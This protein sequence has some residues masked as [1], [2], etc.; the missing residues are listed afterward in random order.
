MSDI[1]ILKTYLAYGDDITG[2]LPVQ[3]ECSK[4]KHLY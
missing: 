3:M 4:E 1:S 2:D